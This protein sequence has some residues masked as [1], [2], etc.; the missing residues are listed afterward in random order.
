MDPLLRGLP[1]HLAPGGRA[2]VVHNAFL[3]LAATNRL[4][5]ERG[6]TARIVASSFMPLAPEKLPVMA[7]AVLHGAGPEAIQRIGPHT[8]LR[9]DVLEIAATAPGGA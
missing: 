1:R 5:A 9:T 2:Y 8:F 3:G 6:L 7:P 4:L